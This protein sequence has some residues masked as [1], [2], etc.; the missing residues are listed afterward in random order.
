MM[1]LLVGL[2]I[3]Q[4]VFGRQIPVAHRV[5]LDPLS[6]FITPA[7]LGFAASASTVD[8]IKLVPRP[9]EPRDSL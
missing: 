5:L 4:L 7:L 6:G 8:L 3:S 2:V 9:L 1:P